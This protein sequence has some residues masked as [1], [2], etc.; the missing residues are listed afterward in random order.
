MKRIFA[1]GGLT[2]CT[3][4]LASNCEFLTAVLNS[5]LMMGITIFTE[6][7]KEEEEREKTFFSPVVRFLNKALI[8]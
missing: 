1:V 5:L 6:I 4:L 2:F 3:T 7:A 8:V